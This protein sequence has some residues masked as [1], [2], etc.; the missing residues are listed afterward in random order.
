VSRDL[1]G[2]LKAV[3]ATSGLSM[4]DIL[5]VGMEK[6]EATAGSAYHDGFVDGYATAADEYE[7][8]YWCA[9]CHKRHLSLDTEETKEAGA[10]LMYEAG[11][12]DPKCEYQTPLW[13]RR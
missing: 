10:K 5:K 1:Y 6:V 4:A 8:T 13:L 3:A 2:E 12:H 9:R 11:W 7:V